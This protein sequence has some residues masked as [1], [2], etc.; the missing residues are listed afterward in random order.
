MEKIFI[1][2]IINIILQGYTYKEI[3]KLSTLC[4]S[5]NRCIKSIPLDCADVVDLRFFDNYTLEEI[6]KNYKFTQIDISHTMINDSCKINFSHVKTLIAKNCFDITDNFIKMIP[7]CQNL[8][9][10]NCINMTGSFLEKQNS[11]NFLKLSGCL[12]I[13]PNNVLKLRKCQ[14]LDICN[15]MQRIPNEIIEQCCL[16]IFQACDKILVNDPNISDM[17][18]N[19]GLDNIVWESKIKQMTYE[20]EPIIAP[21]IIHICNYFRSDMTPK[22]AKR[23]ARI[24]IKNRSAML[25][26]FCITCSKT[27]LPRIYYK[28]DFKDIFKMA[29]NP[30]VLN[31]SLFFRCTKSDIPSLDVKIS[32]ESLIPLNKPKTMINSYYYHNELLDD[33]VINNDFPYLD[34]QLG[35]MS[36]TELFHSDSIE[37]LGKSQ[38]AEYRGGPIIP[39]IIPGHF[40]GIGIGAIHGPAHIPM[41]IHVPLPG[42][43]PDND[44]PTEDADLLAKKKDELNKIKQQLKPIKIKHIP[45]EKMEYYS[46]EQEKIRNADLENIRSFQSKVPFNNPLIIDKSKKQETSIVTEFQDMLR[47]RRKLDLEINPG[48]Y[49]NYSLD[50]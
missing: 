16:S 22:I 9:L 24:Y 3:I 27:E 19:I 6:L 35:Y 33:L 10:T 29:Q 25:E 39:G 18:N 40:G 45:M 17:M 44:D 20:F 15:V 21:S 8:D 11:W 31:N 43:I 42:Y 32:D 7:T 28:N 14:I 34:D 30:D 1:S 5:F 36:R 50:F 49:L 47:A 48:R 41:P 23:L 2:D 46:S 12:T 4:K 26:K 38:I 37:L 13:D